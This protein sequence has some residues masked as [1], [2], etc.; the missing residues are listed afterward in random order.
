MTGFILHLYVYSINTINIR[1]FFKRV[2][3]T[4]STVRMNRHPLIYHSCADI[5][6]TTLI[7]CTCHFDFIIIEI[8]IF[9][10]YRWANFI[11]ECLMIGFTAIDGNDRITY[12]SINGQ[13]IGTIWNNGIARAICVIN[14]YNI[15]TV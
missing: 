8:F 3:C 1:F 13:L 12:S 5:F 11:F 14:R 15:I 6:I 7:S 2:K 4:I 10:L 9:K